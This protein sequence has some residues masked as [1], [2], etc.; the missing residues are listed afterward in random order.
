MVHTTTGSLPRASKPGNRSHVRKFKLGRLGTGLSLD[1]ERVLSVHTL[2]HTSNT[3]SL[4][5]AF[6]SLGTSLN[7]QVENI[8]LSG[9]RFLPKAYT[10]ADSVSS[11]IDNL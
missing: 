5:A 1:R 7:L 9:E 6:H 3:N 4:S 8:S 2:T 11:A 10:T